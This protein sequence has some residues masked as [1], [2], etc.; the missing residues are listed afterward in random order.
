MKWHITSEQLEELTFEQKVKV[1]KLGW[2]P[3]LFSVGTMIELV[4]RYGPVLMHNNFMELRWEVQV[5]RLNKLCTD[6]HPPLC[7][8]DKELADT[9]WQAVKEVLK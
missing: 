5:Y 1:R 6:T 7:Y 8:H 2:Q 4:T 3:H 9:L